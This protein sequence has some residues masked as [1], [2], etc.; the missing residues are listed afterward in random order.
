[1]AAQKTELE[2]IE[3][4]IDYAIN[5]DGIEVDYDENSQIIPHDQKELA[6][7]KS[8]NAFIRAANQRIDEEG[9]NDKD[10]N[11]IEA[12]KLKFGKSWDDE[13]KRL[14]VQPNVKVPSPHDSVE[15]HRD[16]G[17]APPSFMARLK[18]NNYRRLRVIISIIMVILVIVVII[19]I[20]TWVSKNNEGFTTYGGETQKLWR[21]TD[22]QAMKYPYQGVS[23][24]SVEQNRKDVNATYNVPEKLASD[25]LNRLPNDL[26][27][28]DNA[29]DEWSNMNPKGKGSLELKNMLSAG[30]HLGVNTQGSSLRNANQG[31]RSEPPNPIRPVS[32]FNNS[33]ITPDP[34]R[35]QFEINQD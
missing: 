35:K 14:K 30:Q 27:P 15:S 28:M 33:T 24:D 22:L 23:Q 11:N 13:N 10:E 2:P 9:G 4:D 5:L 7:Y 31:L 6:Y 1:M 26:L 20:V 25:Y 34:Y 3:E 17:I 18:E 19:V 21:A 12:I 32:I 8:L 16:V 29:A